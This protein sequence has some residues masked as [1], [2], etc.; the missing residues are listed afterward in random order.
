V[1]CVSN[2]G[3]SHPAC[4]AQQGSGLAVFPLSM[5]LHGLLHR[6]PAEP[7]AIASHSRSG[8]DGTEGIGGYLLAWGW[9]SMTHDVFLKNLGRFSPGTVVMLYIV[10]RSADRGM[11]PALALCS[12]LRQHIRGSRHVEGP[13]SLRRRKRCVRA[14]ANDLRPRHTHG[15]AQSVSDLVQ[16]A[17]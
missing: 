11:A 1:D 13:A 8:T 17:A 2:T 15:T 12:L 5:I 16:V 6:P 7:W 4:I 10:S 3:S 14:G 9:W